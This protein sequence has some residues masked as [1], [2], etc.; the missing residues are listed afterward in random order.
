MHWKA[1]KCRESRIWGNKIFLTCWPEF[2]PRTSKIPVIL[3]CANLARSLKYIFILIARHP[4]GVLNVL[5]TR[6]AV[7]TE[8]YN[9]PPLP[10]PPTHTCGIPGGPPR[11][12][13]HWTPCLLHPKGLT[14]SAAWSARMYIG[15]TFWT[16]L[17]RKFFPRAT[18]Q[19]F[20]VTELCLY[21]C[22]HSTLLK[23][24]RKN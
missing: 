24:L 10:T 20:V 17:P 23:E 16:K 4:E 19:H 5:D 13:F 15:S 11:T 21:N 18:F 9:K 12:Y 22:K 3:H 14:P 8:T 7:S 6:W 2:K 1:G